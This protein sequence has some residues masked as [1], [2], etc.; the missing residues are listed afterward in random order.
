MACLLKCDS[1]GFIFKRESDTDIT[2]SYKSIY[3]ILYN[4][5]YYIIIYE[6]VIIYNIIISYYMV[7]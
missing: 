2:I 4:T 5:I 6:Y 7:V 1:Y 3:I